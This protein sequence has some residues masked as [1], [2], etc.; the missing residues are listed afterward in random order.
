MKHPSCFLGAVLASSSFSY[1][2]HVLR[3]VEDTDE[4]LLSSIPVLFDAGL[5][6][7]D[8]ELRLGFQQDVCSCAGFG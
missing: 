2:K 3:A 4:A 6:L 7:V 1:A 5:D 8:L